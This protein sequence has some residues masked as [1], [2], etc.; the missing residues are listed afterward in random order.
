MNI[1]QQLLA[2]KKNKQKLLAIL[3]DPDKVS[4]KKIDKLIYNLSK[5]K[6]DLILVGGSLISNGHFKKLIK[7]LKKKCALPVIIFPGD[8]MQVSKK[9]D[10]I[11][12]LSLISGRNPEYLIGKQ[13]EVA[14]LLHRLKTETI[15]TGYILI[16]NGHTTSVEYISNTRPIPRNKTD[17]ALATALAG[18]MLGLQMLYLE[19][20]SGAKEPVPLSMIEQITTQVNIPVWV[21]GGIRTRKQILEAWNAGADVVVVGTA[22]EQG[23]YELEV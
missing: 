13:V 3:L 14:P 4:L 11:L 15:S 20:G 9:A 17:I 1:Q 12:L 8:T 21:G 19:A 16:E 6:A 7:K 22:F 5:I 23:K 2:N 10:A 18:Q